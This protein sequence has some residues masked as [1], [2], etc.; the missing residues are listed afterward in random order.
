MNEVGAKKILKKFMKENFVL[1]DNVLDK[2][3]VKFIEER[4]FVKRP[5]VSKFQREV[6]EVVAKEFTH[7]DI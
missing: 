3:I 4:E 6:I 1:K 2:S 5:N 7:N